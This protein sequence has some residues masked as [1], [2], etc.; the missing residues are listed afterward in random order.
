MLDPS[1]LPPSRPSLWHSQ[2]ANH[3]SNLLLLT[4][5]ATKFF[6]HLRLAIDP[7]TTGHPTLV[8]VS[9]SASQTFTDDHFQFY[10]DV[11][12]PFPRLPYTAKGVPGPSA[13]CL[14]VHLMAALAHSCRH[15]MLWEERKAAEDARQTIMPAVIAKVTDWLEK[16]P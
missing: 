7:V 3:S 10:H 13:A 4:S 14:L 15:C 11:D 16:T 5:Q 2:A 12:R 6:D 8:H 9:K 1:T